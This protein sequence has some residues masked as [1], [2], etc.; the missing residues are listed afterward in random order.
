MSAMT[1]PGG[2]GWYS[3]NLVSADEGDTYR[4]DWGAGGSETVFADVPADDRISMDIG[5]PIGQTCIVT[6][7]NDSTGDVVDTWELT[8]GHT[9][10]PPPTVS[11]A[12]IE[13]GKQAALTIT[14]DDIIAADEAL[15]F[16][17]ALDA[18]PLAL[19]IVD[20]HTATVTVPAGLIP[21]YI[22]PAAISVWRER[23]DHAM[24]PSTTIYLE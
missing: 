2:E 19:T 22:H 13:A 21:S 24:S 7:R 4:V 11:P 15:W 10:V 16:S 18:T 12:S 20:A 23:A 9:T 5:M 3:F 6:A 1:Y 14:T 17:T 8:V